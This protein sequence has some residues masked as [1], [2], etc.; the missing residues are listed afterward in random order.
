[1][2]LELRKSSSKGCIVPVIL[3]CVSQAVYR[4]LPTG[5]KEAGRCHGDFLACWQTGNMRNCGLCSRHQSPRPGLERQMGGGAELTPL[6]PLLIPASLSLPL[7]Q[8]KEVRTQ[9]FPVAQ[10]S[11]SLH[12]ATRILV[13]WAPKRQLLGLVF[14]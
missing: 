12:L 1:M 14:T 3:S 2:G 10:G 8:R 4:A 7:K 9:H 5:V 13:A 6:F 11:L